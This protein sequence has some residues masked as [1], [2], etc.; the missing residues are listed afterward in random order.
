MTEVIF[1]GCACWLVNP[2]TAR[3]SASP[4]RLSRAGKGSISCTPGPAPQHKHAPRHLSPNGDSQ[5]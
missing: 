2:P 4:V 1:A 5:K 3:R